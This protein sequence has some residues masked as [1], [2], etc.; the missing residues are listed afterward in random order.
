MQISSPPLA[1]C[2]ASQA[3]P[4]PHIFPS[5]W[6]Q[7]G[8][9][10]VVLLVTLLVPALAYAQAPPAARDAIL[11]YGVPTVVLLL[12]C[13]GYLS[14]LQQVQ[15]QRAQAA[16][17]QTRGLFSQREA[18]LQRLQKIAHQLPGVV[19]Q[20]RERPDG[21]AC[22][23]FVSEAIRDLYR[24]SPEEVREDA[25]PVFANIHPDDLTQVVSS[26]RASASDLTPWRNEH[27]VRFDDGV[28][29]WLCGNAL[30]QREADGGVLWHGFI[31]DITDRKQLD[32]HVSQL[33]LRA[34]QA[35]D[36]LTADHIKKLAFYDDLTLLPNRRLLQERLQQALAGSV[37]G[38]GLGALLL[39][40]IDDFKTVNEA[41][42]H[43]KG[44]ALLLKVAKQLLLC[45]RDKDTVAR[46]GGDEFSVILVGLSHNAQEA[47]T[48][49]QRV[50]EN[51]QQALNQ[52]YQLG[53][54]RHY[55]TVTIGIALLDGGQQPGVEMPMQQAQMALHQAQG[56]GHNT[57]CFF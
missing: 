36:A 42:G 4:V 48:Q 49:A 32:S 8:G 12:A 33:A 35:Q 39:V 41:L 13:T 52:T 40:D 11:Q 29:R 7:F 51:I 5:R 26:I 37:S 34:V 23:P 22:F 30:P 10:L 44:D 9:L 28:E 17:T 31:T 14:Y 45:V 15:Q 46:L 54:S 2:L 25:T 19:Y 24:V 18:A 50:A 1:P 20:Y 53:N 43:H 55:C 27:R 6:L 57:L 3:S 56:S 21:R 47:S 16:L 38:A